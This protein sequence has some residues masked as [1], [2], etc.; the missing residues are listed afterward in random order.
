M[1]EVGGRFSQGALS[2]FP[3]LCAMNI[4]FIGDIFASGGRGIVA[5]FLNDLISE[6]KID[7][8]VANAENSAGGFGITPA[9]VLASTPII[10]RRR[11]CF[12]EFEARASGDPGHLSRPRKNM[13]A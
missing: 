9:A 6:H 7:L 10:R 12:G 4:L 11:P 1:T 3:T 2:L 13:P 5:D 8:A